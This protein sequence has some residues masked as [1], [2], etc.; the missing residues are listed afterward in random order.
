MR[1]EVEQLRAQSPAEKS[2]IG[3]DAQNEGESATADEIIS[4]PT[5]PQSEDPDLQSRLTKELED[6]RARM[7]GEELGDVADN[8]ALIERLRAILGGRMLRA[9]DRAAEGV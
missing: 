7:R 9:H 3:E 4:P 5:A 8:E 6:L 2:E 1:A